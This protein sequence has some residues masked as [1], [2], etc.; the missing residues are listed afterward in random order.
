MFI[1]KFFGT[2]RFLVVAPFFLACLVILPTLEQ[3]IRPILGSSFTRLDL[4]AY[5]WDFP[6]SVILA[7]LATAFVATLVGSYFL[8]QNV[9]RPKIFVGMT[10]LAL[11]LSLPHVVVSPPFEAPDE[12][13]H[14]LG[15]VQFLPNRQ[16]LILN[17]E[18]LSR[19]GQFTRIYT[20]FDA[21]FMSEDILRITSL[22]WMPHMFPTL[23]LE[24][25][26]F[27]N[28]IWDVLHSIFDFKH[29]N[30]L[31][32][33]L[34]LMG[35]FLFCLSIGAISMV[36]AATPTS[37]DSGFFIGSV[38]LFVPTLPFFAMHVSNYGP[39]TSLYVLAAA[40]VLLSLRIARENNTTSVGLLSF[41]FGT[42]APLPLLGSPAAIP[43]LVFPLIWGLLILYYQ[44]TLS[45]QKFQR[46]LVFMILGAG[47]FLV[48]AMPNLVA[49]PQEISRLI[50]LGP[51][52]IFTPGGRI[53]SMVL[54]L[55]GMFAGVV[56]AQK[57]NQ[58]QAQK[59]AQGPQDGI[60][61]YSHYLILAIITIIILWPLF[62][63]V[64]PQ[65]NIEISNVMTKWMYVRSSVKKYFLNFTT[66]YSDLYLC[67]SFWNGFG[68]LE[69]PIQRSFVMLPKSVLPIAILIG[70]IQNIKISRRGEISSGIEGVFL[71]GTIAAAAISI[72]IMAAALYPVA[73]LH[74][75]YLI[76]VEIALIVTSMAYLTAN[77]KVGA[78]SHLKPYFLTAICLMKGITVLSLMERYF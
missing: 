17:A 53:Y 11:G 18:S 7:I 5:T 61:K 65:P 35:S 43:F 66:L 60:L 58:E 29:A 57:L 25:S 59:S 76:G 75:R 22:P 2:Q 10:L 27:T 72:G 33:S 8:L 13:D 52:A 15:F 34:R 4:L 45:Y 42:L 3:S 44:L 38:L 36:A 20:K 56:G 9:G 1:N 37:R 63:H 31:L 26:P 40:G 24:R 41:L 50:Q 70:S 54:L 55:G 69:M 78:I 68:W 71:L 51:K 67:S 30:T 14:F 19:Q 39:L 74:G 48:V 46:S 23:M 73:N 77:T 12:P 16:E 28:S 21:K 47:T 6:Q 64:E 49:L 32:L 62:L